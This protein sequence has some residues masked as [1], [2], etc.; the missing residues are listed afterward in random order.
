MNRG[1][2]INGNP[3]F[4]DARPPHAPFRHLA[5]G[6][7]MIELIINQDKFVNMK[8]ITAFDV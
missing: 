3:A 7:I 4:A 6:G 2:E 5:G 1:W 8:E